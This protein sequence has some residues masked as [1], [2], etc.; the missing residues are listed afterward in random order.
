MISD[1]IGLIIKRDDDDASHAILPPNLTMMKVHIGRLV[2]IAW[3]CII[4]RFLHVHGV[5]GEEEDEKIR[6]SS[7]WLDAFYSD[8]DN[9]LVE[10]TLTPSISDLSDLPIFIPSNNT[11][12]HD[13]EL[14]ANT[15]K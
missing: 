11:G 3:Y 12:E 2:T 6:P 15:T 4:H 10:A 9:V 8:M 5:S 14:P 7:D 13:D 1:Q